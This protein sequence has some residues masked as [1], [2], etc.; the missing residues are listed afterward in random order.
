VSPTTS[1]MRERSADLRALAGAID[2][3]PLRP[4]ALGAGPDTWRGPVADEFATQL[5]GMRARLAA[6]ADT[7]RWE[8]ARLDE[9][10]DA[11]DGC[12]PP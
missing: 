4:L 3:T 2:A 5:R 6:A 1:R 12:S 8:A 10:A 11:L 9:R 7:L